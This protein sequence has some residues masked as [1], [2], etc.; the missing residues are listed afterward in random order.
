MARI[1]KQLSDEEIKEVR[2]NPPYLMN[3]FQAAAFVSK[4]VKVMREWMQDND[5]PVL[6]GNSPNSEKS[7]LRDELIAWMSANGRSFR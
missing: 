3:T 2:V 5:F 6:R 1:S 4:S 7:V